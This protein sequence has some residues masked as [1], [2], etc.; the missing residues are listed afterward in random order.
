MYLSF[1]KL[2]LKRH[3]RILQRSKFGLLNWLDIIERAATY[4]LL[5]NWCSDR[6]RWLIL[7]TYQYNPYR[8]RQSVSLC[9]KNF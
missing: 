6:L 5:S 3:V 1:S 2:Q 9:D 7:E 4:K 8:Y